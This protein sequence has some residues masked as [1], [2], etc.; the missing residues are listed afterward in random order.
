VKGFSA[1][2]K[3]GIQ[4]P[5]LPLAARTVPHDSFPIPKPPSDWTTDDEGKESFSDNRHGATTSIVH[6]DPDLF[7]LMLSPHLI[8]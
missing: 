3:H 4:Y 8:I 7:P 1:K 2:S 5:N 6:K